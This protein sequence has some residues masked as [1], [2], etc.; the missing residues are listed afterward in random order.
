MDQ[1]AGS[2]GA[3]SIKA[4]EISQ[5]E[6]KNSLDLIPTEQAEA[7]QKASDRIRRYRM[8]NKQEFLAIHR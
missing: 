8:K 6:L 1:Q 7:L 3:G 4:L 2:P 5:E